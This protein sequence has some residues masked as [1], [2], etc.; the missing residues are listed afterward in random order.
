[1]AVKIRSVRQTDGQNYDSIYRVL[2]IL[3]ASHVA[4]NHG[5]FIKLFNKSLFY[6][7]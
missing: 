6:Y 2:K 1:M 5:I 4:E 3:Q 7:T